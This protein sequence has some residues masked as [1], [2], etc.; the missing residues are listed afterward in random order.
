MFPQLKTLSRFRLSFFT[1]PISETIV[2]MLTTICISGADMWVGVPPL[3]TLSAE[4]R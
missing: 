2:V 3:V 1:M 4:A